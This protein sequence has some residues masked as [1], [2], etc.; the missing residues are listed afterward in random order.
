MAKF[1]GKGKQPVRQRGPIR[2]TTPATT[3]TG[4]EGFSRDPK[5]DL[6]LLALGNF[7]GENTFHEGAAQRDARFE[8]L[9]HQ[10][11]ADDPSWVARFV[12]Y[13][14]DTMQMRSASV[15]M[16]AEYVRA[17]GPEGRKVVN[18]ACVRADEPG[19]LLA[20]WLST[21]G[22]P[23]PMAIRRGLADAVSRLYTERNV[24]KYDGGTK[25]MR[26][27]DVVE[28]VRPK[29]ADTIQAAL[30]RALLERRHRGDASIETIGETLPV[31]IMDKFLRAL[32]E[33]QRRSFLR[34]DPEALNRGAWTWERL[35]G[36]LPGGMD[37]EAWEFVIPQM[38][39]MALLRNL[40][41]FD[42]AGISDAAKQRIAGILSDPEAVA[43]SRQFPIRFYSAWT[44]VQGMEW[45]PV[46]EKA[47]DL[48]LQNVPAF[49]GKTLIMI[50]CSGSMMYTPFSANSQVYP[51]Q[52]AS[53]FGI[54]LA[55]RGDADVAVYSDNAAFVQVD[56]NTSVLRGVEKVRQSP[57]FGGGTRTIQTLAKLY[58]G[59]DRVVVLTDEQAFSARH[60]AHATVDAI[61][62]P[63]YTF[64]LAG[65]KT[66]HLESGTNN[67]YTFGGG[68]TDQ[69]FTILKV[70]EDRKHG[71]WP[72]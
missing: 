26:F 67:R 21:Y 48:S 41:N 2:T 35:S 38:G 8:K 46:L 32:P 56:K 19:E 9:V 61:K 40:R 69:A 37:A 42:Q 24:I 53:V 5:S 17:G 50:D 71:T 72:F 39:Y 52:V 58:K 10:V 43:K 4:G 20:Y 63:I 27:G 47:L 57:A 15:V 49:D 11:V 7:V 51:W 18:A 65:Y 29:P 3:A 66:G 31:L 60:G 6:F 45:G 54:A 25:D 14:R 1:S 64:N 16:A 22:R 12:P 28:M 33:K 70:L 68:L 23:V 44:N 30:F 62:A 55:K 34:G 59:H 36:W 13:L